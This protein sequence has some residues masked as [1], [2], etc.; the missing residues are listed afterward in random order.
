M[1][2]AFSIGALALALTAGSTG[3]AATLFDS[4]G[5]DYFDAY[6]MTGMV[7]GSLFTFGSVGSF[8]AIRFFAAHNDGSYSGSFHWAIYN[9]D[10]NGNIGTLVTAAVSTATAQQ[11]AAVD[12]GGMNV[13][14]YEI[15]VPTL[16]LNPGSYF[17][18]LHH[19]PLAN[20][21]SAEFF[22]MTAAAQSGFRTIEGTPAPPGS[23]VWGATRPGDS[24]MAY[25]LHYVGWQDAQPTPEP[26]TGMLIAGASAVF[27]AGRALRKRSHR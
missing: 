24:A 4:G 10:T 1:R 26:S 16:P 22:W 11:L 19:G 27:I 5:P 7:Q 18:A 25:S 14:S 9:S 17:L 8:D 12:F 2:K 6:E 21:I 13:Y 20:D 3:F 15:Q 23:V